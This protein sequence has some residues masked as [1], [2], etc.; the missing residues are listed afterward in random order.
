MTLLE[1]TIGRWISVNHETKAMLEQKD[2]GW[3]DTFNFR[4]MSKTTVGIRVKKENVNVTQLCR[5]DM[6]TK[7]GVV[8]KKLGYR[9]YSLTASSVYLGVPRLS[10]KTGKS[11]NWS[12]RVFNSTKINIIVD[13]ITDWN[14]GSKAG[15]NYLCQMLKHKISIQ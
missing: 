13:K 3:T 1:E 5:N 12:I 9:I 6:L 14:Q 2:W 7:I 4:T 15:S 8:G 10:F 11:C